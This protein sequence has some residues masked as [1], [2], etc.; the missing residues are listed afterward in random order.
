[1]AAGLAMLEA[2]QDDTIFKRLEDKTRYLH[3]GI[4]SA[5]QKSGLS[6]KINRIGSMISVHFT[7]DDVV[8]FTICS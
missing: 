6:Y 5:L 4:A 7:E 3:K 8:D 2:L 1:M